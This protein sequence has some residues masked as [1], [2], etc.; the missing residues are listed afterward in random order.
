[1]VINTLAKKSSI[2]NQC[3]PDKKNTRL[4]CFSLNSLQKI[5]K[6][7]NKKK[8]LKGNSKITIKNKPKS[9]LLKEIKQKLSCEVTVDICV[10]K[11]QKFFNKELEKEIQKTFKP[12]GPLNHNAWLWTS[13]IEKVM[14]Q[15]ER[16]YKDFEFMGPYPIDFDYIFKEIATLD[17]NKISKKIKKIGIIFN[18][19]VST[20]KGEHWISLFIDLENR[21]I[22]FFDSVGEKPP[23]QIWRLIKRI[24]K[25]SSKSIAPLKVI[26]NQKKYQYFNSACGVFSLW[27]IISRL[28]GRSCDF[29]FNMNKKLIN[30]RTINERRK[31]YFRTIN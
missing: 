7:L 3:A 18:T 21:T 19:D 26:V 28:K 17:I 6:E 23:V 11:K 9:V 25:Q 27:F 22:C 30:D 24:E 31:L 8:K 20:G 15:Y 1:M 29:L 2:N 4:T 12:V 10:L 16:K 13:H 5:A 14:N